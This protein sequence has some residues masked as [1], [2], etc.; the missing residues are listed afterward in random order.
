MALMLFSLALGIG[1]NGMVNGDNT[2]L[3]RNSVLK[4]IV[5]GDETI[6]CVDIYKQLA[7]NHPLLKN[8]TLQLKPSSYPTELKSKIS[9]NSTEHIQMWHR[10]GEYCPKGTVAILRSSPADIPPKNTNDLGAFS[11]TDNPKPSTVPHSEFAATLSS[12]VSYYGL[13]V[14]MS[15][16]SPQVQPN[17]MST[18]QVWL[19]NGGKIYRRELIEAGWM[20]TGSKPYPSVFGA[21]W[22]D[23][24]TNNWWLNVQGTD[25]G[26]WPGE[27]LP[28]MMTSAKLI[29][30]G[31][32]VINT[33]PKGIHTTTQMGSGHFPSEGI[34]KAAWF[35]NLEYADEQ[36]N[37]KDAGPIAAAATRNKCY[38]IKVLDSN[39]KFGTCFLYGGPGYSSDCQKSA[40]VFL[41]GSRYYG[42]NADISAW[43]PRIQPNELSSS[44]V[45]MTDGAGFNAESMEAGWMVGKHGCYNLDCPGF[46]QT[47]SKVGLGTQLQPVSIYGGQQYF[48]NVKIH[49]DYFTGNWWLSV[50]G[51]AIGYW[52]AIL[53]NNL[54]PSAKVVEWGGKVINTEPKGFHTTTQMGSGH[55]PRE[56]Y[57]KAA[58]FRNL[59]FADKFGNYWDVGDLITGSATRSNCYDVQ[60]KKWAKNVGTSFLYGGPGFSPVCRK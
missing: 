37:F 2:K 45:W 39:T 38:D 51:K 4:T 26:Y 59:E 28:N 43:S 21:Y 10:N 17:E 6:D 60:I 58:W 35:S 19:S 55:F 24:K 33:N 40:T 5:S 32:K 50:E 34:G 48:I 11:N 1:V 29:E 44:Q 22:N 15:V 20:V 13:K 36:L 54:K 8:H 49:K 16:W 14:N 56:G 46:V 9:V 25:I 53:F 7:F 41:T 3:D 31:G 30:W 57:G 23:L 18:S 47:S 42:L 52:P 27:L 12:G